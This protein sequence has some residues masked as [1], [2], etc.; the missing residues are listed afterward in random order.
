M[1]WLNIGC[2]YRVLGVS[3]CV[4][5]S[6]HDGEEWTRMTTHQQFRVLGWILLALGV[7]SAVPLLVFT[8]ILAVAGIGAGLS[9]GSASSSSDMPAILSILP[10]G[11]MLAIVVFALGIA[12]S[13]IIAGAGLLGR[14]PWART[15]TIVS[16][17][18]SLPG[19]PIWTVLGVFGL[20]LM[21]S[22]DGMRAWDEYL[23]GA[24]G[25][26]PARYS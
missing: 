15:A 10:L 17:I 16:S 9:S 4:A 7:I 12:V 19:A 25:P 6:G 3:Y 23:R 13:H 21:Y 24:D 11:I 8:L 18:I 2:N 5:G 14:R 1:H 20:W 22:T 26:P